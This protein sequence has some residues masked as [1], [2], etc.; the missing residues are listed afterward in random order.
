MLEGRKLITKYGLPNIIDEEIKLS[1]IQWKTITRRKVR[2][3][4]EDRLTSQ[5]D[6]YSKLR[7]GPLVEGGLEV[8]PY[9]DNL[10]MHEARTMF[11]IRTQ[12]M[13]T[14]LNMKN[15]PR[16]ASEQWKCD[17]CKMLDS[18]SHIL[19]CPFFAPLREGKDVGNDKDLVENFQK[20]FTIREEFE[21][22]ETS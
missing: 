10:K 21:A 2:K 14:K 18:Q 19:W 3:Y 15:N 17:A 20:V 8:K 5:F 6:E 13:P 12:M 16:F 1:R 7:G 11:R 4:S 22:T 9:I